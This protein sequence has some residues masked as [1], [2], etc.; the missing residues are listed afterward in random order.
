M[1]SWITTIL[2]FWVKVVGWVIVGGAM[3]RSGDRGWVT[4]NFNDLK[5]LKSD[6]QLVVRENE[7][8]Q[9]AYIEISES[10]VQKLNWGG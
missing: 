5:T 1:K 6:Y 7:N 4:N 8:R 10:Q 2:N 3:E 9:Q